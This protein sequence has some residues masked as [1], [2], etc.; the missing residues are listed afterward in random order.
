LSQLG[1]RLRRCM[2]KIGPTWLKLVVRIGIHA[3]ERF[4]DLPSRKPWARRPS[5]LESR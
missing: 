1:K 5:V 2:A 3:A 4:G